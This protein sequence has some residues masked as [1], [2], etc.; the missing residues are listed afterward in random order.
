MLTVPQI[1]ADDIVCLNTEQSGI[2]HLLDREWLLTNERGSYAASSMAG[3]N[4]SGY[5]GLLIGSL[6][7]PVNRIMALSNCLETVVCEGEAFQLSTFDFGEKLAPLGHAHLRQFRRDTGVHFLYDL[8]AVQVAKAIYL[9]R[10]SDTV[11]VE[12]AFE[13]IERPIDFVLRP[14]VGLRD[15][16][17]LQGS[18]AAL[19][20]EVIEEGLLVRH[21]VPGS[22]ELLMDCPEMRFERDPQWWF[23]FTY[24]VN[25]QRG[26]DDREDLWTPGFFK[27]PIARDGRVV[28]RAHFGQRGRRGW[29]DA[30]DVDAVRADLAR[31]QA[32]IITQADARDRTEVTL[33]LAADQF[34]VTRRDQDTERSTIVAGYPWFADWGRD[35]FIAL[36]GLLLATGRYT[37][38]KSVLSTF[39]AAADQGM[40]PNRFD[41]RQAT[42]HFNSVDASLWFINAAFQYLEATGD[43]AT[44]TQELLPAIREIIEAYHHG[45]RFGI[46]AD[47]DGLILAGDEQTQLTWMDARFDGI[48]FT[49]RWGKTVEV[50]ALWHN[51]LC[52]LHEFCLRTGL[53]TDA[54]RYA[55]MAQQ[56]GASFCE[57]FWNE[58]L[59]YLND[60]IRPD[61]QVD[62]S[63]RPNQIFAVSLPYGPP[64]ERSQ[65][66]AIVNVV[67]TA[68]LTPRGLRTLDRRDESYQ[69]RY[70]GPQRQRDAA[71]HQGTAWPY[72]MGPFI[73]AYLK[74]RNFSQTSK[75]NA[76]EM[77]GPLL[78]H[79]TTEG[80]LGS[81]SEIFD[82]DEPQRPAGCPAQAWSVGELIRVYKLLQ[83]GKP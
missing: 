53:M 74:V 60:T 37:E 81:I 19:T 12:Y 68:L 64:L 78:R 31:R 45:T 8:G 47:V 26:Q 14:F 55:T 13:G 29:L 35:A 79:L 24:R 39:A 71:Y 66:K 23:N 62:A 65:Q 16:H 32:E 25:Q 30:I 38:A 58:E 22:Y 51:A 17:H 42:A 2:E 9:V 7:P 15:F 80:C 83:N 73:E 27:T 10:N 43:K 4:T 70:E 11:L 59:G 36:P 44:F 40:I 34:V 56:V 75:K 48:T 5:H 3:C 76:D 63:L 21:D 69:G 18:H 46:H 50:N 28:F 33:V 61:G 20:G 77:I 72:L 41:D 52:C 57:V 54:E 82:G 6:N 49:P 1:Q 67:E